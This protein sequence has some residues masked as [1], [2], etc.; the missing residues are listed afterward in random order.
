MKGTRATLPYQRG[1]GAAAP[2]R[3]KL[4]PSNLRT[5][6]MYTSTHRSAARSVVRQNVK[7]HTARRKRSPSSHRPFSFR[8]D[9]KCTSTSPHPP[10]SFELPVEV[11]LDTCGRITIPGANRLRAPPHTPPLCNHSWRSR[12]LRPLRFDASDPL[13]GSVASHICQPS[14]RPPAAPPDEGDVTMQLSDRSRGTL[15]LA[16]TG[17]PNETETETE[18]E[19]WTWTGTGTGWPCCSTYQSCRP[20]CCGTATVGPR[21]VRRN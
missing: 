17:T 13:F 21:P 16:P 18:T 7:P 11:V 5:Q 6:A 1:C 12:C 3:S 20:V 10:S 15:A 19:T 2:V 14:R 4:A 8:S 9:H